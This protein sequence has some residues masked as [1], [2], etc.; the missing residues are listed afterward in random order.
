ML[1]RATQ[2]SATGLHFFHTQPTTPTPES[3]V[4][5]PLRVVERD[6]IRHVLHAVKWNKRRA[7]LVLEISRE[8]LYRKIAEFG[9]V[10][11]PQS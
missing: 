11:E 1:N 9:L 8:T 7:A 2:A 6:H 5:V 4:L 3:A 10:Q